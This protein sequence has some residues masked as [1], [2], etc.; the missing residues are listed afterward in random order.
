[1]GWAEPGWVGLDLAG[2]LGL[3]LIE[4]RS[5]PV[6]ATFHITNRVSGSVELLGEPLYNGDILTGD[7]KR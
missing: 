1:M 7:S 6:P 3:H 4:L 2:L 5:L